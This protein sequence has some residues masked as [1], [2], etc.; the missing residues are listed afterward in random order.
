MTGKGYLRARE[1][2]WRV[3]RRLLLGVPAPKAYICRWHA[4]NLI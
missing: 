4:T 1:T 2:T 3:R